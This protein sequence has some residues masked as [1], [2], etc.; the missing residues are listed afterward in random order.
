MSADP[1]ITAGLAGK[2]A[3]IL[4]HL[5]ERQ[6]RLYLG[7][8]ARALGGGLAAAVAVVAEAAGV[9][10]ATVMAGA[11]ELAGGA[12]LMPGRARRPGAGRRRLEDKDPGLAAALRELLKASTRGDPGSPLRWTTLSLAEIAGEL[13]RRGHRCR[14]DAAARMLRGQ[15]YSLR[16]NSRTVEGRRHPDRDGQFRYINDLA[17]GFLAAGDPVVSVDAK[18]K[19]QVGLYARPGRTWRPEGDP[20]RV[21]DHDFPDEAL[22]KVTPYGIYDIGANTGF[23]NVG[24]DHDTAA[25]A[26]ESIRRWWQA[27]GKDRYPGRRR[28]LVTCDAGGSNDCRAR[29]W[30]AGLA[31]LAAQAGLEITVCHFPPGTSK[32]NQIEHRLFSQITRNW[33]GRPLTSREVIIN[34]IAAVTTA[35]GLT[36]QAVLDTGTYPEKVKVSDER[37]RYLEERVLGRH[38]FHGE[39]NYA[40]RPAPA[41]PPQQPPRPGPD[42]AALA[43]LAGVPD[44]AALLAAVAVPWQAA[45]EQ[46][47]HL[48][49]G[50]ARRKASGGSPWRLPFEA[51]AAAAACH[52]RLGMPYR[53]LSEVLGAHESTISVPV[54]RITPLLEEHGI[55]QQPGGTRIS[56]LS[57]LRDH[58]AARGITIT[59]VTSQTPQ[60]APA[61]TTR[62]TLPT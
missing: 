11:E 44:L 15:G 5:G 21:R 61:T 24:T 13:T 57:E 16:G 31:D 41:G 51:I 7:S 58:A 26:V 20:V 8:E 18:K 45:R 35:T 40:I 43:A 38:D 56:T 49:R 53:L 54:C 25:F 34:T 27:L 52:L 29:A 62:P 60:T 48:A 28:L 1:G 17:R 42:L 4:P 59:G 37:M 19:E 46:R 23:V 50:H 36:V 39:W 3:E 32:W 55:T 14:K 10:R 33:R 12:E 6:R 22:G 2:F 9:S 47:L 30:K